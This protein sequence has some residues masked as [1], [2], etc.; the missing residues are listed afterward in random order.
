[1]IHLCEYGCGQTATHYKTPSPKV[2]NGRWSCAPSPNSCPTKRSKTSGNLN[3][4][5]RPDVIADIKAKNS[6]LFAS[7]S[8]YRSKCQQ[9]LKERYGVSN[10]M[11]IPA[12]AKKQVR[13]RRANNN[14]RFPDSVNSLESVMKREATRVNRGIQVDPSLL[15]PWQKYEREVDRLTLKNYN[16]YKSDINPTDLTRGRSKGTYQ[17]DHI[18]SKFDGFKN[19]VPA[20]VIAHPKNLRMLESAENKKKHTRSDMSVATLIELIIG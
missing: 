2:P 14:Y 1:M 17:L 18:V 20:A 6:V 9:T 3:P 4:S 19:G 10:P 12:A 8:E 11:S 5:R 7:G 16:E 13:K 15:T